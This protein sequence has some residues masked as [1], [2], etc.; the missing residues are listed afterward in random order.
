MIFMEPHRIGWRDTLAVSWMNKQPHLN[1]TQK[2]M[3]SDMLD[4]IAFKMMDFMRKECVEISE[5][6]DSNMCFALLNLIECLIEDSI[7]RSD[8]LTNQVLQGY[9]LFSVIW[10]IG[11]SVNEASRPKF[12]A[13][14]QSFFTANAVSKPASFNI[15][16]SPP[17]GPVYEYMYDGPTASWKKWLALLPETYNIPP[18]TKYDDILVPT[19]DTAR[20]SYL[21]QLL[22][23][24]SKQVMFVGPT[25]TGKSMY[26]KDSLLNVMNKEVYIPVFINFSARTSAF[27]TQEIIESKLDKRRKGVF[28]PVMGKKAVIF[29]DDLNMPAKEAYGAQ[30]PIELLRQWMDHGGWYNLTENSMQEFVDIQFVGAMGPAGGGRSPITSRVNAQ[31]MLVLA[32][33]QHHIDY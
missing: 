20:Y 26:I 28:G 30:P 12:D 24:Y 17:P 31:L 6:S 1:E 27:Q 13:M 23:R 4:W 14:L 16:T 2:S 5:T 15:E 22:G 11:G 29:V 3:L 25:G 21:L 32:S 19:L 33:L 8:K 9:F 10:S 7:A 18:K